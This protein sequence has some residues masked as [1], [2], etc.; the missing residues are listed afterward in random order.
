MLQ[1]PPLCD[2]VL[3]GSWPFEILLVID[4]SMGFTDALAACR[5]CGSHV[6]LEMLDWR[7]HQR[8][9]R[10][11][12]VNRDHAR[13]LLHNLDRGSCDVRRATAELE[14]LRTGTRFSPW[15]L[16]LDTRTMRITAI[17]PV[18]AT[19]RL[20]TAGW[21]ALACDGSWVDYVGGGT[22]TIDAPGGDCPAAAP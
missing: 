1:H 10:L 18:P 5:T 20:P 13:G 12:P 2:H 22:G 6:L 17:A 15:L 8:V 21:R 11:S 7:G 4:E 14:Q 3:P 16:L 9:M 19:P